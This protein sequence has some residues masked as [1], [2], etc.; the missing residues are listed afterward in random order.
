MENCLVDQSQLGSQKKVLQNENKTLEED[1][2]GVQKKYAEAI[3]TLKE[4]Q[5][6]VWMLFSFYKSL[7]YTYLPNTYLS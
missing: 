3:V 6:T 7:K 5:N 4:V 1:L 2:V